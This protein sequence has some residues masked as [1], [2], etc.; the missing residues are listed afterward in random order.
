MF[1]VMWKRLT[2]IWALVRGDLRLLW[3]ALRHPLAPWWLKAGTL[4]LVAYLL[5]PV[6][7]VPD[8]IPVLGLMDDL[9]LI[10]LVVRF[11]LSR[12]PAPL[13]AALDATRRR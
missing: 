5:W 10:P 8:V 2:L 7:L 3:R 4:A 13:L 6:D 11:M 12:L 1:R 9:V